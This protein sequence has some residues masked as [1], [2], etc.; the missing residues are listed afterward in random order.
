[1][2]N[3]T[4]ARDAIVV[5]PWHRIRACANA[6]RQGNGSGVT[7]R[8]TQPST[9]HAPGS[10]LLSLSALLSISSPLPRPNVARSL[11]LSSTRLARF[12]CFFTL[13][14]TF[15]FCL[16]LV[17]AQGATDSN[18]LGGHQTRPPSHSLPLYLRSFVHHCRTSEHFFLYDLY[19][20][21]APFIVPTF[22]SVFLQFP[23]IY[24][25]FSISL[26]TRA[27]LFW[28]N[29]Q[30]FSHRSHFFIY[31]DNSI[32]REKKIWLIWTETKTDIFDIVMMNLD[33]EFNKNN[34]KNERGSYSREN[35]SFISSGVPLRSLQSRDPLV[36]LHLLLSIFL[37]R[38]R[39]R[40]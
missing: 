37:V 1:M 32:F 34:P 25:S 19:I 36:S 22:L 2:V 15:A 27:R 18:C 28:F 35:C 23:R 21:S 11:F 14:S 31:R 24:R 3:A 5:H 7:A 12:P 38:E 39:E 9:D 33:F 17:H 13:A 26:E 4:G 6:C 8:W 30:R 16:W 10:L 29:C 20:V 40:P